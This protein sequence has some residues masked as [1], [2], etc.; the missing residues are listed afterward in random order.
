M[1]HKA[2][3]V[4]LEVGSYGHSRGG[5]EVDLQDHA[6]V[7]CTSHH[8]QRWS[9]SS[10]AKLVSLF[11]KPMTFDDIYTAITFHL[12]DEA[13]PPPPPRQVT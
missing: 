2:A 1:N 3:V 7:L 13:P 4:P 11:F 10:P 12:P 6:E 8:G 9:L 5:S